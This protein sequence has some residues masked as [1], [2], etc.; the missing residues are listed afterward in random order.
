MKEKI[1]LAIATKPLIISYV[2][3]AVLD[4]AVRILL[5]VSLFVVCFLS[6]RPA[7]AAPVIQLMTP[8]SGPVGTLVAIVGSGFG[9]SQGT[10]TVTFNGTLVTWVSWSATSLQVQVPAGA[11]SG[12]VVVTVSGRASNTKSFTV[13]PPPVISSLSPTSGPVGA[14]VVITGSN[15]TAGGT[16]SP[17]VVFNPELFASPISSTD[18]SITVAV[19]A[20]ASTG[21]LLVSVGGG[22]SN[23]VLFTVSSSDPSISSLA[24]SAGLVGIAV[25]I[26][27]TNFGSP[28]GTSTVTFNGTTGVP[29]S[30]NAT[31]INV[32][33]PTGAT[34]GNVLVTVGRV[35]SNPYGFEVGTAAPNITSI[36]PP[37]GAVATSVT[38]K[39]S[40]FGSTQGTNTVSFNGVSG[41]PTS[42]SANQIKVPVP[43]SATTGSV[44]VTASGTVSNGVNFTVPGT[45]PSVTSLSPSSGPVGA[46]VTIAG[47]NFGTTQGASTVT[48]NGTAVTAAGWSP[49]SIVATVPSGATSGNLVVTVSGTSSGGLNFTVV[50][51]ITSLSPTSGA[52]GTS[53]TIN[54]NSFGSSQGTS[55]VTFNG[56]AATPTTWGTGSIIVPVPAGAA[57]GNVVV[58]VGGV[59]SNGFSFVVVTGTPPTITLSVSPNPNASGWNNSNVMVTAA[60]QA[61][62]SPVT[63]CPAPQTIS[64]EGASQVVSLTATD[65]N[66]MT[67]T[68]SVTLNIDKTVPALTINSPADGTVFTS[69]PVALSGSASDSLSGLSGVTCNGVSTSL[70]SGSFSCSIS[71][72]P[73]VNLV[74]VR[75][76]DVAGNI[77]ASL[78][79]LSLNVPLPP[80]ATLQITPGSANV[81]IGTTQQFTAVDQLGSLRT[82][83]T[84]T[85]DNTNVATISTDTSPILTGVAAGSVTLTASVRG[86][87]AQIQVNILGGASLPVG[88]LQWTA[89]PIPGFTTVS[90]AQAIPTANAPDLY[91]ISSDNNSNWLVQASTSD[92]QQKWQQL[93]QL[94]PSSG[95]VLMQAIPDAS[96]GLILFFCDRYLSQNDC[97]LVDLDGQTGQPAWQYVSPIGFTR[98]SV[99]V[100]QDG[101]IITTEYDPVSE[102]GW[103]VA[104]N[105]VTGQRVPLYD[106]SS[107]YTYGPTTV[108]ANGSSYIL[109]VDETTQNV[110]LLVAS[111]DGSVSTRQVV[112]A[113]CIPVPGEVIPDGQGGQLAT[114]SCYYPGGPNTFQVTHVTPQGSNTF[115]LP[116]NGDQ[117]AHLYAPHQLVLGENGTASAT[118]GANAIPPQPASV[119]SFDINSGQVNWTYQAPGQEGFSI[120]AS[121]ADG[122]LVGELT[123]YTGLDEVISFDSTGSP[124]DEAIS[125]HFIGAG[126]QSQLFSADGGFAYSRVN[127]ANSSWVTPG[128][129]PGGTATSILNIGT[130]EGTAVFDFLFQPQGVIKCP[131]GDSTTSQVPI[132]GGVPTNYNSLVEQQY[133]QIV[134]DLLASDNLT[135]QA[136][137]CGTFFNSNSQLAP[138]FSQL[139]AA[140]SQQV[141]FDGLQSTISMYNSGIWTQAQIDDAAT[142][143]QLL[144]TPVCWT[145]SKLA[146]GKGDWN[147]IVAQAQIQ[148]PATDIYLFSG[149]QAIKN[150]TQ[151]TVLHETLHNL[152]RMDDYQLYKLLT[153]KELDRTWP[154]SVINTVLIQN[155]CVAQ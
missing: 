40:G 33:V 154:T 4:H 125:G 61:G 28:Q 97:Q 23:S 79:H 86:V 120:I 56:T 143:I 67:A 122:G 26:N 62:S 29:T 107:Y 45:G 138:Y 123:D 81:L 1:L 38:I 50:P 151:S 80:P 10:S 94:D 148:P 150:L 137:Q 47:T 82:D 19:P 2:L 133:E 58:T 128:A 145:F 73:G 14:T 20:G 60:C 126:W 114:W 111:S 48:F 135:S 155:G 139:K 103:L 153:G 92:G 3:R 89:P 9:A 13:A 30:W 127:F 105:G 118:D 22:N 15:F 25:T 141:A 36:S 95:P 53:V 104:F 98:S 69:S 42:W 8:Q 136:G 147:S 65:A 68:A 134:S 87:S 74:V 7:E 64:T 70:S 83:A 119:V 49:T 88:T 51:N 84:W 85:V 32:P 99:A 54:G 55:T 35:S 21:D 17:Q 5:A 96:G 132:G 37:S 117:F 39:G 130:Y 146:K 75:A 106:L 131:V 27:G 78:M 46:S 140:V 59:A 108:D 66:G 6:A 115:L 43:A 71:F 124:T 12:N 41:V 91:R 149:K 144:N 113:G 72:I 77:A 11:T 76:T 93:Q 63:N 112:A 90:L 142:R 152:T 18:T 121:A 101:S 24:P 129:N 102:D 109:F 110:D 116:L 34:T 100:R 57:T 52:G 31:S 16:Q 44:V